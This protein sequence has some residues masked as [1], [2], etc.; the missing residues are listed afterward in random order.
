MNAIMEHPGKYLARIKA[1]DARQMIKAV[2]ELPYPADPLLEPEFVGLTYYQVALIHQARL[3]AKGDMFSRGPL[4][5]FTDRIIGKPAQVNFNVNTTES[6]SQF[7][8]KVA[9]AEGEVIDV[10]PE[11]DLG[12]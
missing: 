2:A 3:M 9:R 8:E 4:E 12:L 6:Y 10:L 5:F 1:S 7:L 11:N